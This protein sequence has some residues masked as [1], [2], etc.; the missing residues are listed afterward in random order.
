VTTLLSVFAKTLSSV[1]ALVEKNLPL[2][3]PSSEIL[4]LA[5]S[6]AI[7]PKNFIPLNTLPP[8]LIAAF[9]VPNGELASD[10]PAEPVDEGG[11]EVGGEGEAYARRRW[12]SA[13]TGTAR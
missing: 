10:W 11:C 8:T 4:F 3:F 12:E 13:M 6:K 7:P 2:T 9:P 1:G 5:A